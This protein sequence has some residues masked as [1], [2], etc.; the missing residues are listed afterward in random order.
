LLLFMPLSAF[1]DITE[2]GTGMLFGS[3]HAF[4]ITAADGWVLDNESGVKQDLYMVFY[5]AGYTWKNSPVIAYGRKVTKDAEMRNIKDLVESTVRTFHEKGSPGYKVAKETSVTLPD[6]RKVPVYYYAG[7][8]WGNFEAVA[9]FEA[10]DTINFLVYNSRKRSDFVKYLPG[11]EQMVRSYWSS[12]SLEPVDGRTFKKLVREAKRTSGTPGGKEYEERVV[13]GAGERIGI[14]MRECAS[15][16]GKDKVGAFE[17]VFRIKPDGSVSEA[18][19]KPENAFSICFEGLFLQTK[20]PPHPF[21]S[22][23][24]YIDMNLK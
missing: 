11:F 9:Y 14:L 24:L 18:Y 15:Y 10:K 4:F 2:K 22:Y 16:V 17:A 8:Q 3:G 5:P 13:K 20:H 6:G 1:A 23:L 7:D 21:A 19:V 12:G